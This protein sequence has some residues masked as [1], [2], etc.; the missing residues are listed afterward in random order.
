MSLSISEFRT[1]RRTLRDMVLAGGTSPG[2]LIF[3]A[4]NA[5]GEYAMT[6]AGCAIRALAPLLARTKPALLRWDEQRYSY[7]A[8]PHGRIAFTSP[9]WAGEE[10]ACANSW[11]GGRMLDLARTLE[12]A[13]AGIDFRDW[14]RALVGESHTQNRAI[15]ESILTLSI[16]T[17]ESVAGSIRSLPLRDDT[18]TAAGIAALKAQIAALE[19]RQNATETAA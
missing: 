9:F 8:T 19:A 13:A 6:Q 7:F 17:C 4:E 15:V 12:E 1:V 10:I 2:K 18:S 14:F 11:D 5:V 16:R 3:A